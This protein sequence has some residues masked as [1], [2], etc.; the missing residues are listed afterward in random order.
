MLS[1]H[2][3]LDGYVSIWSDTLPLL[4]PGS[5]ASLN[6][7]LRWARRD[8]FRIVPVPSTGDPQIQDYVAEMAFALSEVAVKEECEIEDVMMDEPTFE[9][10]STKVA[11][12]LRGLARV[13][14]RPDLLGEGERTEILALANNLLNFSRDRE[15]ISYR[16]SIRGYGVIRDCAGDLATPRSLIEVKA[17]TRRLR[18]RDIRQIFVYLAL[19]AAHTE[20]WSEVTFF[21]PKTATIVDFNAQQLVHELSGGQPHLSVYAEF[22]SNFEKREFDSTSV[23]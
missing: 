19:D 8:N 15:P 2:D 16:P 3:L 14:L 7:R 1:V 22:L 10:V 11:G 12:S 4:R 23:G 13:N 17:V 6:Q 5:V 18:S 21:N 20:R 9:R